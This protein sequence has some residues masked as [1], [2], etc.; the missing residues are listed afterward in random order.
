MT[1]FE[2]AEQTGRIIFEE[3]VGKIYGKETI[4]FT[5]SKY[6]SI[7]AI[8]TLAGKKYGIEIK[9][10]GSNDYPEWLLE[11]IKLNGLEKQVETGR[12]D[13]YYYVVITDRNL[14]FYNRQTILSQIEETGF[15]KLYCPKT[16][17]GFSGKEEKSTLMLPAN[18]A[19]RYDRS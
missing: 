9:Y 12:V 18:K 19:S 7:D 10:R 8:F 4:E 3:F 1:K 14:F 13:D 11:E 2:Q 15:K 5:T 17:C 6:D 16:T